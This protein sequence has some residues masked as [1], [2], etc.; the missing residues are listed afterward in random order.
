MTEHDRWR[1]TIHLGYCRDELIHVAIHDG[2]VTEVAKR[3]IER[4]APDA[5]LESRTSLLGERDWPL[6]LVY[7]ALV[8]LDAGDFAWRHEFRRPDEPWPT[9]T[10]ETEGDEQ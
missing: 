7:S 10:A 5:V 8:T 1:K 9:L 3:I 6:R 2:T 4:H